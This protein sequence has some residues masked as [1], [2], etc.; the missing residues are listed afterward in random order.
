[1]KFISKKY[2]FLIFLPAF[3]AEDSQEEWFHPIPSRATPEEESTGDFPAAG[4]NVFDANPEDFETADAVNHS[5]KLT[6]ARFAKVDSFDNPTVFTPVPSYMDQYYA[7]ANGIDGVVELNDYHGGCSARNR[8]VEAWFAD[9]TGS[10]SISFVKVWPSYDTQFGSAFE[11]NWGY[12]WTYRLFVND[13]ECFPIEYYSD[14]KVSEL[15][16]AKKPFIFKCKETVENANIIRLSAGDYQGPSPQ[17]IF[18]SEVEIF[19]FACPTKPDEIC[20]DSQLNNDNG[21][22]ET[23]CGVERGSRIKKNR[24]ANTKCSCT[25][26]V[27][28]E[29]VEYDVGQCTYLPQQ[30]WGQKL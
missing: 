30:S 22:T 26:A 2:I 3:L 21:C 7:A 14:A 12:Y 6:N 28:N 4:S 11:K 9:I 20:N 24:C 27:T 19:E 13:V 1:M 10:A 15:Y 25:N 29:I 5:D 16:L 8:E 23:Y 17:Y 18:F